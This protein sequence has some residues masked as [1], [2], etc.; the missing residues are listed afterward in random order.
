VYKSPSAD[1]GEEGHAQQPAA[2]PPAFRPADFKWML[3]RRA[4]GFLAF[5]AAQG[6]NG[7]DWAAETAGPLRQLLLGSAPLRSML[8]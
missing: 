2:Q 7:A 8:R 6:G 1:G 4:V 5:L 3:A